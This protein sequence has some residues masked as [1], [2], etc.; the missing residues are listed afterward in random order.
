MSVLLESKQL[1]KRST[2]RPDGFSWW[3]ILLFVGIGSILLLNLY[4]DSDYVVEDE[5]GN[6]KLSEKRQQKLNKKIKE[7]E[8][9]AVQYALKARKSGHYTCYS[10]PDSNQIFLFPLEVWKYGVTTKN[11]KGRYSQKYLTENNLFFES[12]FTG[13]LQACLIEEQRK[14]FYYALLA[15]NVKRKTF[16]VRPPGNKIDH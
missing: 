12:Q 4:E 15:E 5:E 16:L 10:C 14:I 6:L 1:K 9:G 13:T 11:Q 8:S 7:L 2:P 3:T